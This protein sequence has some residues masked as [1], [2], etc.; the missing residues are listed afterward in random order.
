MKCTSSNKCPLSALT[1]V[2]TLT[3]SCVHSCNLENDLLRICTD[4]SS[5]YICISVCCEK[6]LSTDSHLYFT[7]SA[8][9]AVNCLF[10]PCG[11][12]SQVHAVPITNTISFDH[13]PMYLVSFVCFIWY[14]VS[15]AYVYLS[16]INS[17]RL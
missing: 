17:T 1:L 2:L 15:V 4:K 7:Q 9:Y 10:T 14:L 8:N 12:V 3:N 11:A 5:R 13:V 16:E 6:I